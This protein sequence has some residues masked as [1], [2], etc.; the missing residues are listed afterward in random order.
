MGIEVE[1]LD[2]ALA[3]LA[4]SEH[5]EDGSYRS[6]SQND[7]LKEVA[8]ALDVPLPRLAAVEGIHSLL[9]TV[10]AEPKRRRV[11]TTPKGERSTSVNSRGRVRKPARAKPKQVPMKKFPWE[12]DPEP[13]RRPEPEPERTGQTCR[14]CGVPFHPLTGACG[15]S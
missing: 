10:Q 7:R 2:R 5:R 8:R 15:C 9:P 3:G 1:D 13:L 12:L 11:G 14:A 6:L 4:T